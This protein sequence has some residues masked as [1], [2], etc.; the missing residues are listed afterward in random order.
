MCFHEFPI[1]SFGLL[2][3]SNCFDKKHTQM[4]KR[5]LFWLVK[6]LCL[7]R[8]GFSWKLFHVITCHHMS[9][10]NPEFWMA[11][12]TI[13]YTWKLGY[14]RIFVYHFYKTFAYH[15][16]SSAPENL[17]TTKFTSTAEFIS[18]EYFF[19][20]LWI[21]LPK[22]NLTLTLTWPDLT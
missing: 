20:N 18:T 4:N 13:F 12:C 2:N 19:S 6:Y 21:Y 9:T 8:I 11:S 3:H 1:L 22:S 7:F 5:Y 10:T 17:Y 15:W 14:Y 16:F